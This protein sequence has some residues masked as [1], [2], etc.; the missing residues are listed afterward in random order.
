MDPSAFSA[1]KALLV[2][3]TAV[4]PARFSPA[5]SPPLS[6]PPQHTVATALLVE[7]APSDAFER[8]ARVAVLRHSS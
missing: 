5:Q 8:M 7:S 1:A 3:Y 2:E 6:E 4:V